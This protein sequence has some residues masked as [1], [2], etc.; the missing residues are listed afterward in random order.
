MTLQ[1]YVVYTFKFFFFEISRFSV[2]NL[3]KFKF[4]WDGHAQSL[5]SVSTQLCVCDAQPSGSDKL[6][7]LYESASCWET[8][9]FVIF[10][11]FFGRRLIFYKQHDC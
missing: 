9:H 8:T 11:S 6:W 10:T 1:K 3:K 4:E 5:T 7:N 2:H